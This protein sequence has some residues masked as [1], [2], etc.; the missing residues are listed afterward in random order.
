MERLH[1]EDHPR[2]GAAL[3]AALEPDGSHAYAEEFR[4]VHAD[5]TVRS[6]SSRG[7]T[8]FDPRTRRPISVFSTVQDITERLEVQRELMESEA[9]FRNLADHA[10]VMIWVTEPDGSCSF[11]SR[12]WFEF[13]GQTEEEGL[14][15]GWLT[16]THPDDRERAEAV[17]LSA[18]ERGEAFQLEYRLRRADGV[19]RW[20]IDAATPRLSDDGAFL[21]YVGSVM[22]IS[23]RHTMEARLREINEAQRRFVGD[24]AHELRAPLTSIRGNLSLLARY[25]DMPL[26]DRLAAAQEAEHE[27][28]RLTRLISDLLTVARGEAQEQLFVEGVR[29]ERVLEE[30]WRTARGLAERR[31]YDLKQLEPCRVSGDPDAL[32]QLA[33]ILLENAVKYTPDDGVVCLELRVVDGWAEFRI[34]DSGPGI[35]AA[36]LERV[37][38]RFYR[39]DR[40]RSR[41]SGAGGTGLGLTIARAIATRHGGSVNLESALGSGTTAV[42]RLP[43]TNGE[44][45]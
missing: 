1:P 45:A 36:D 32:K 19:Y 44:N 20:A 9:R 24:A 3:L 21:G 25:P 42:V 11:L 43:L 6:V 16:A 14:G 10:P 34:G 39:T 18:N 12:S 22:D 7:Q 5:G 41:T 13:T 26:E 23:E 38:E 28:A 2:V 4:F 15:F 8:E 27:A 33:L 30:A 17:F 35:A 37:F 29:L 31:R 40:A